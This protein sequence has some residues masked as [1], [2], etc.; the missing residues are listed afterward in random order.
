MTRATFQI[1][2]LGR[3][4][5]FVFHCIFARRPAYNFCASSYPLLSWP[6]SE[7]SSLISPFMRRRRLW[8]RKRNLS[9][10]EGEHCGQE[11]A[12]KSL[13][14]ATHGRN[15]KFSLLLIEAQLG[16]RF[17]ADLGDMPRWSQNNWVIFNYAERL[18]GVF[19]RSSGCD[20]RLISDKRSATWQPKARWRFRL[21]SHTWK[22]A[23]IIDKCS[24]ASVLVVFLLCNP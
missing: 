13:L 15:W 17:S 9:M 14:F 3:I 19:T 20:S 24:F 5:G 16:D 18:A 4:I 12:K 21:L 6:E 10:N 8:K 11:G 22:H 23:D 2:S 7:R 1:L